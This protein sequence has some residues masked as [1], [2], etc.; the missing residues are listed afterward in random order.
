[1]A[2]EMDGDGL[3]ALIRAIHPDIAPYAPDVAALDF[4][5]RIEFDASGIPRVWITFNI[6][7]IIGLPDLPNIERYIAPRF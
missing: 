6:A 5:W 4:R 3:I 2:G 7:A 1:M